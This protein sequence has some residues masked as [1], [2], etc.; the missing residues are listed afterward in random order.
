MA[1]D[2][3]HSLVSQLKLLH[4]ATL[5]LPPATSL[6]DTYDQFKAL[7]AATGHLAAAVC[8]R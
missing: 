5:L 8:E 7:G 6:N 3:G 2:T 4:V 1:F